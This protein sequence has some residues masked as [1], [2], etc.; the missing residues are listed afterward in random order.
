M[1][2]R[3]AGTV[4]PPP[5]GVPGLWLTEICKK[6]KISPLPELTKPG[7]IVKIHASREARCFGWHHYVKQNM[8]SYYLDVK[9]SHNKLMP[10]LVLLPIYAF[11]ACFCR[12]ASCICKFYSASSFFLL[13]FGVESSHRLA[14]TP[15]LARHCAA[16][17]L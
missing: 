1:R 14:A 17:A 13:L 9:Q 2:W 8:T 16:A 15:C 12:E 6:E 7:G 5:P 3:S 10:S 11:S 4:C